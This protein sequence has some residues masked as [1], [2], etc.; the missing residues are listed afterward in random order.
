MVGVAGD[1]SSGIGG[2][3]NLISGG[4]VGGGG[5][6]GVAWVFLRD[7]ATEGVVAVEIRAGVTGALLTGEAAGVGDADKW[8][9]DAGA[10]VAALPQRAC[11]GGLRV[12]YNTVSRS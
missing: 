6:L 11:E 2:G 4:A 3:G 10:G 8:I 7:L 9:T 12:F 5:G 1:L